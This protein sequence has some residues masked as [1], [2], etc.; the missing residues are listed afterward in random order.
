MEDKVNKRF[1]KGMLGRLDWS[2]SHWGDVKHQL[3]ALSVP[4]LLGFLFGVT[5]GLGLAWL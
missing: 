2:D 3:R 5:L 4:V 1:R